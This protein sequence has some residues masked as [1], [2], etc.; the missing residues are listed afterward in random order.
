M[1]YILFFLILCYSQVLLSQSNWWDKKWQYRILLSVEESEYR[2]F[3]QVAKVSF[4]PKGNIKPD[5]SDIRVLDNT[6]RV[7]PCLIQQGSTPG[8]IVVFFQAASGKNFTLY[9]GNPDAGQPEK[10][11]TFKPGRI[12]LQDYLHPEARTTGSWSWVRYPCL[13]GQ[14]AHTEMEQTHTF[15]GT[16]FVS[17]VPVQATDTLVQFVFLDEKNPPEQIM[18]ELRSGRNR[19][20]FYWGEQK[21]S[22]RGLSAQKMGDLPATGSWQKLVVALAEFA[23]YR[24]LTGLTFYHDKG[25]VI[26]DTSSINEIPV[27]A[28]ITDWQEL[29]RP[30]SP[31]F[32]EEILGPFKFASESFFILSLNSFSGTKDCQWI[33]CG[34]KYSGA[35]IRLRVPAEK[36]IPVILS[37]T[38]DAGQAVSYNREILLPS[39]KPEEIKLEIKNVPHPCFGYPGETLLLSHQLSSL[40]SLPLPLK[41]I[42]DGQQQQITL[43]PRLENAVMLHHTFALPEEK[44]TTTINVKLEDLNLLVSAYLFLPLPEVSNISCAGPFLFSPE[45]EEVIVIVPQQQFPPAKLGGKE[46]ITLGFVGDVPEN[47]AELVVN[48]LKQK[49]MKAQLVQLASAEKQSYHQLSL[50]ANL[51]REKPSCNVVVFFPDLKSLLRKIPPRLWLPAVDATVSYLKTGCDLV[52]VC[53]PFPSPPVARQLSVYNAK[54]RNLIQQ[55]NLPFLDLFDLI[56]SLP[57]WEKIFLRGEGIFTN[58]PGQEGL[59]LISRALAEKIFSFR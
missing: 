6:G 59:K 48:E 55:R 33:I 4:F 16:T 18:L 34:K 26:W 45:N 19:L 10:T 42:F 40:T 9:Y 29:N 36:K 20:S 39:E 22:W 3:Q 28:T 11:L 56:T 32:V 14:L 46:E 8:E 44:K 21:I 7:V 58:L 43:L 51:T 47:L 23:R 31:Y 54:L 2:S 52:L 49:N 13:S 57:D 1:R 27:P 17:P 15:H 12:V 24:E 53:S 37:V 35:S 30:V 38:D 5:G 25:R 41:I 50:F